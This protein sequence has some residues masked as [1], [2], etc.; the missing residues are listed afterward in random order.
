MDK[1]SNLHE[2]IGDFR[3]GYH[4][5]KTNAVSL[6]EGEEPKKWQQNDLFLLPSTSIQQL[7]D[8]SFCEDH[9]IRYPYVG[10]AMANGISS[11]KMVVE[12]G[13]NG[14]LGVFG[15]GGL[16]L[17]DIE[18]TILRLK[19]DLPNKPFA[20]NLIHSPHSPLLEG[21]T[22]DLFIKHQIRCVEASAFLRLT[23]PIVRYR[24]HGLKRDENGNVIAPNKVIAKVS[25]AEVAKQFLSPAPQ[26]F[27]KVLLE[28]GEITEE[29]AQMALEIPIAQDVTAEADSGGH[30]DNRPALALLPTIISLKD[31]LQ[32]KYQYNLPLRIGAA[33]GIATPIAAA[34]AFSMGAAYIVTGTVNQACIESGSSDEVRKMLAEAKQADVAMAPSAGMFEIGAKVQVL[35]EE[36]CSQ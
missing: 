6:K 11:E 36:P 3:H 26:K 13:N 34:A 32:E 28:K 24:L 20:I 9:D 17:E 23:L 27:I 21:G 19:A 2:V 29:Q 16:G 22:V 31:E 30:T 12:M 7:G 18:A 35:K 10:G 8:S 15:A 4:F 25:R 33:G 1:M 14:M 5:A